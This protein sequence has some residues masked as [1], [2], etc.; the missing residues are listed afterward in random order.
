VDS[1]IRNDDAIHGGPLSGRQ[2]D[3]QLTGK[4]LAVLFITTAVV[5]VVIFLSGVIFGRA[6]HRSALTPAE[7]SAPVKTTMQ[8]AILTP[9]R[10]PEVTALASPPAV[11]VNSDRLRAASPAS[12]H[13]E[14][15][16]PKTDTPLHR[17]RGTGHRRTRSHA[18]AHRSR[19]A[20]NDQ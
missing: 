19:S 5:S 12:E 15:D 8:G 2:L 6:Q 10:E 3:I 16:A 1:S 11:D 4:H 13:A 18:A 9:P 7:W 17:R 20:P 14:P